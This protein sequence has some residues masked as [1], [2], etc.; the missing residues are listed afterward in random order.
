MAISATHKQTV[1]TVGDTVG[2]H[3]QFV[4]K[5]KTQR[6]IF[7]GVVIAIKGRGVGRTFMVRKLASDN[8]GVERIWPLHSPN[9][10]KIELKKKGTP[11]RAKLYYL[12]K[13]TGRTALR[14]KITKK[15]TH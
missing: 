3:H 10:I 11:R 8:V 13:R 14:V 6:Q 5:G 12:R 2:V 7:T 15:K 1:F 9:L 4:S